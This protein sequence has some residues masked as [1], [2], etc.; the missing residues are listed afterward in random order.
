MDKLSTTVP[1]A[2][3][4][5]ERNCSVFEVLGAS[6]EFLVGPQQGDEAPCILKGTIPSGVAIPMHCHDAV[7]IFVL[8]SGRDI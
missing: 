1:F 5:R 4:V 2:R 8:L 7:E 3:V 6:I